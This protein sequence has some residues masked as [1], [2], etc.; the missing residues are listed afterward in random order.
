MIA[1]WIVISRLVVLFCAIN[2]TYI[3]CFYTTMIKKFKSLLACASCRTSSS[4]RRKQNLECCMSFRRIFGE[5]PIDGL[6]IWPLRRHC[7]L[8][9][10]ESG[11][12][13]SPFATADMAIEQDKCPFCPMECMGVSDS[14]RFLCRTCV[15]LP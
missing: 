15:P 14:L 13:C 6:W 3:D 11:E 12:G 10:F 5:G 4:C 7:P 9:P 8:Y 1:E 2:F